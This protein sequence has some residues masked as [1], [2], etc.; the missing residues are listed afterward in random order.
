[1][2]PLLQVYKVNENSDLASIRW[3]L[4]DPDVR[5]LIAQSAPEGVTMPPGDEEQN[6]HAQNVTAYL[7][8]K[9]TRGGMTPGGFGSTGRTSGSLSGMNAAPNY[10]DT[11]GYF[12]R[13]FEP[14]PRNLQS[15]FSRSFEASRQQYD[16]RPQQRPT[17]SDGLG[18]AQSWGLQPWGWES[19]YQSPY[20]SAPS[21]DFGLDGT[22]MNLLHGHPSPPQEASTPV[23]P[24]E[25][26]VPTVLTPVTPVTVY[27]QNDITRIDSRSLVEN[28]SGSDALSSS[29]LQPSLN[30]RPSSAPR[31]GRLPQSSNFFIEITSATPQ[32]RGR[33]PKNTE[34]NPPV[35]ATS[36][37]RGRPFK[38][39]E[40]AARAAT[41]TS[42]STD[43]ISKK[44][45]RP[46]KLRA[47]LEIPVPEPEYIPFICEWKG[48]PAELQNLETLEVHVFNVHSKKQPSSN[49]FCLWGKC[50]EKHETDKAV[51]SQLHDESN[52]FRSKAEWKDHVNQQHLIPFA[53]HMGDGPKGTSLCMFSESFY[54]C[55]KEVL[56]LITFAAIKPKSDI[57]PWLIDNNGH[58]VTPS[59]KD[60]LIEEG[61]A[62]DNNAKRFNRK[63]EGIYWV[64]ERIESPKAHMKAQGLRTGNTSDGDDEDDIQMGVSP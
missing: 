41:A 53:W 32:K 4:V 40:S 28:G 57:A 12:K 39:T 3:D 45:G 2:E 60:Q 52:E 17:M 55:G 16:P 22:S 14:T 51:D 34:Q 44:R 23:Q 30:P 6:H 47:Q 25:F 29:R 42:D 64:Y 38:T 18:P 46:F 5:S 37:K 19:S 62:K 15:P 56:L 20:N 33:P 10:T 36:K 49:R 24:Q 1:L 11:S 48:C 13:S 63:V 59:V 50:G 7:P 61:R 43:G 35:H 8:T 31:R 54:H 27:G 9:P 26:S 21:A 58:H